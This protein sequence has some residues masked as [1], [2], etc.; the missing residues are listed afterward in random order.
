MSCTCFFSFTAVLSYAYT[1]NITRAGYSR[2]DQFY[3]SYLAGTELL[4]DTT[5]LYK[6]AIGSFL[7]SLGVLIGLNNHDSF[8]I[9][10]V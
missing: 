2:G 9:K 5:K 6:I 3:T 4:V 7:L 8:S 1:S 10:R